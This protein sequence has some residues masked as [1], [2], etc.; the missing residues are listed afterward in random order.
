MWFTGQRTD[1]NPRYKL[2]SNP[3][4]CGNYHPSAAFDACSCTPQQ[5]REYQRKVSGPITDR[6]DIVRHLS[7]LKPGHQDR[8]SPPESSAEVRARVTAA[9]ERQNRR[10]EGA[11]WRLNGQAPGAALR[12][13]WPLTEEA[14]LLVDDQVLAGRLTRRGAVR[15]HRLAW[16]VTDL[17]GRDR[18]DVV[19]T[20]TALQ[21]RSGEALNLSVIDARERRAG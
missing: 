11:G 9:R 1:L 7:P 16:T 12:D 17:A 21:L 5:R 20:R 8:L 19:E 6:L 14:Q 3:C 10:Y 15:V 4:L 2:A 18:P 13:T